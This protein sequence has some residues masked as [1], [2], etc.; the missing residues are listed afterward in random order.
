MKMCTDI[1]RTLPTY[2]AR[3]KEITAPNA[4]AA[5][6]KFYCD[7]VPGSPKLNEKQRQAVVGAVNA[8]SAFCIQ[9]PPGTGK[10]TVICEIVQHLIARGERILMVAPTHVAIDEVLRRIGTRPHVHAIRLSWDDSRVAEDVRQYMPNSLSN[11]LFDAISE[12][13]QG[14][15]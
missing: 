6:S 5:V 10:T 3:Q 11:P 15:D 13:S 7:E 8:P 14:Q 4:S 12:S 9:G 2:S 1:G